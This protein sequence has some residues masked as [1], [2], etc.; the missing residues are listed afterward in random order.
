MTEVTW[1][2]YIAHFSLRDLP[3][4]LF[5]VSGKYLKSQCL[6]PVI[7]TALCGHQMKRQ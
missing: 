1:C 3:F 4:S 5:R 7:C 6:A 2:E